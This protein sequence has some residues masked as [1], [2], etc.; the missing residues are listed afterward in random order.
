MSTKI[1]NLQIAP[2]G[3]FMKPFRI[4]YIPLLVS[5]YLLSMFF[6]SNSYAQ[7]NGIRG[8]G[9]V[10]PDLFTGTMSYSIPIEV[11][12]GRK[13]M[14]PNLALT[15]HSSNGNGIVGVGW[16]LEVGAIERQTKFGV[17]YSGDDYV[18]RL[19]GNTVE[20]VNVGGTDYRAKIEGGFFRVRKISDYWEVTDK[21]GI[22]YFFG[23][24]GDSRQ[25]GPPGVFK[26][27]LTR[28]EDTNGNYITLTYLPKDQGQVYLDRIDYT[29]P[30]N[31]NYVRFHYDTTRSDKPVMYITNYAVTTA[32]RLKAIDVWASSTHIRAYALSYQSGGSSSTGR[33]LLAS[34][35]QFDKN[36]SV[37]ANGNVTGGT[38]LPATSVNW[39]QATP[40]ISV[41]DA[42]TS[43]WLTGTNVET[44]VGD[45]NGDGKSDLLRAYR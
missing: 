31:A 7:T 21:T 10:L 41:I 23:Q 9:T 30:N 38:P 29:Y 33:S 36:S 15:Y 2:F 43:E 3:G 26:W 19:A 44:F 25:E 14:Q 28:I 16:E 24:T 42:V 32:K 35:Q 27:C 45:F 5:Y 37:D 17:N 12:S 6:S 39:Q 1:I 13:G 8:S 40:A 22:R 18:L 11:P 34:I 20:L 4:V